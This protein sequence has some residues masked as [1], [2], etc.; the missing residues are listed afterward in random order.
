MD[1][2]LDSK[3]TIT[4]LFASRLDD[5]RNA[6]EDH[7]GYIAPDTPS[8]PGEM[9]NPDSNPSEDSSRRRHRAHTEVPEEYALDEMRRGEVV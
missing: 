5:T 8:I 1:G 2:V 9:F 7:D 4:I 6:E 3:R